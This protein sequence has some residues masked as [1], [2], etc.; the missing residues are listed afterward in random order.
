MALNFYSDEVSAFAYA[1]KYSGTTEYRRVLTDKETA[2]I[3]CMI[4]GIP[5]EPIVIIDNKIVA[6]E[7]VHNAVVHFI[8]HGMELGNYDVLCLSG[9]TLFDLG[10]DGSGYRAH[11]EDYKLQI[12]EAGSY[13]RVN[14]DIVVQLLNK[15]QGQ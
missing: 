15:L 10:K 8:M 12:Y 11:I 4:L 14:E 13:Q 7:I 5:L 2:V 3:E 9:K 1:H 6:G